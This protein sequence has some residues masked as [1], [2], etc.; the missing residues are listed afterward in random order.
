MLFTA[1]Y[2]YVSM[3]CDRSR[4]RPS[5]PHFD[6]HEPVLTAAEWA[7]VLPEF[8]AYPERF[9]Q[10]VPFLLASLVFHRQ[11]LQEHLHPS[12]PL[13]TSRVWT[14]PRFG[15]LASLVHQGLLKNA[16]TGLMATG[17]EH[18]SEMLPLLE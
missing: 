10:V 6:L 1:E 14:T 3:V 11:W 18:Y 13:F 8:S 5:P 16:T 17:I 9:R 12:H 4:S 15:A 2:E 7:E